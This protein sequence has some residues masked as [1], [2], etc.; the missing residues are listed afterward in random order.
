MRP[1][2]RRALLLLVA[3]ARACR[4]MIYVGEQPV[5]GREFLL[6]TENNLLSLATEPP[7]VPAAKL[8]PRFKQGGAST[9]C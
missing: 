5:D 3:G 6:D 4:F 7:L 8:S 9:E 2:A 1:L